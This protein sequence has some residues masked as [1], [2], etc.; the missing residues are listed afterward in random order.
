MAPKKKKGGKSKAKAA[1]STETTPASALVKQ[2]LMNEQLQWVLHMEREN[3][4]KAMR[5]K[6]ELQGRVKKLVSDFENEET[7]NLRG[8]EQMATQYKGM[9]VQ[10][11]KELKRLRDENGEL[12][13]KIRNLNEEM[14][15][16]KAANDKVIAMKEAEIAELKE[17]VSPSFV[18]FAHPYVI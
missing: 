9:Q 17:K 2:R 18:W 1:D 7:R 8:M 4:R 10:K 15:N 5:E 6:Q 16:Q 13:D 3:A 12:E 14:E 11:D